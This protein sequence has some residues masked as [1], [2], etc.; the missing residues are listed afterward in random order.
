[1]REREFWR[2]KRRRRNF[3]DFG[4]YGFSKISGKNVKKCLETRKIQKFFAIPTFVQWSANAQLSVFS[5][6]KNEF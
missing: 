4:R 5:Q 6:K 2:E 1:M 3:L